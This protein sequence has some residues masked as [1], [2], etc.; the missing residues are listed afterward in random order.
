[1]V[2]RAALALVEITQSLREEHDAT[3]E[4]VA[5]AQRATRR[6]GLREDD[7]VE[8][9]VD[10]REVVEDGEGLGENVVWRV[11]GVCVV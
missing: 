11:W 6:E 1:M 10:G 9:E 7:L 3:R 8:L 4:P 5:T 2:E